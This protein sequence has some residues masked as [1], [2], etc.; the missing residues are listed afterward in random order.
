M[1][2]PKK[3]YAFRV[4]FTSRISDMVSARIFFNNRKESNV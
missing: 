2:E 1:I 3:E 4:K